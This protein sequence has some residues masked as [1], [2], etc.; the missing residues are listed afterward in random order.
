[1]KVLQ[2]TE[3]VKDSVRAWGSDL[4]G[5][6]SVEALKKCDARMLPDART[7]VVVACRLSAAA[8]DS[9]NMRMAQYETHCAYQKLD[10]IIN[11]LV[12]FLEDEG[13]RAVAVPPYLPIEMSKETKGLIGDLSHRHAAVEAGLGEIGLNRL[14]ITQRFGPRVRLASVLTNAPLKPDQKFAERI[15]DNCGACVK[16]CPVEAITMDGFV[17]V[18]RCARELLKYAIPGLTKFITGLVGMGEEEVRQTVREPI[19]WEFWQ[20]LTSGMFYS[21]FECM[22]ACPIGKAKE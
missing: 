21:C 4:V 6:C 15:C 2:L 12:V 13:Y 8:I 11:N 7:V 5:V 10:Q 18:R 20:A 9:S 14:L 17:D 1:V 16:A 19:F 22:K 3:K